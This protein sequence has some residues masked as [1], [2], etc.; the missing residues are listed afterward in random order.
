[1]KEQEAGPF[2][3]GDDSAPE[4]DFSMAGNISGCHNC[5]VGAAGI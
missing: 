3:T 4:A 2:S 1:M 5:Q